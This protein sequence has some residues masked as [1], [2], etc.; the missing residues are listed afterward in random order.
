[1]EYIL[2]IDTGYTEIVYNWKLSLY[3]LYNIHQN[4]N[5]FEKREYLFQTP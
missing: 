3:F 2:G 5:I 1:M 4:M